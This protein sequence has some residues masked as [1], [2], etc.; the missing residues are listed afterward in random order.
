MI[1]TKSLLFKYICFKSES[2]AVGKKKLSKNEI[3]T[4]M[5]YGKNNKGGSFTNDRSL[6]NTD[7]VQFAHFTDGK[8]GQEREV[9]PLHGPQWQKQA[10][11]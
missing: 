10:Q 7:L 3:E 9:G 8:T 1:V 11:D 2:T 6:G 5:G 4:A